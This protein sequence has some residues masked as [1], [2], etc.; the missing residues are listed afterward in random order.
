MRL[1]ETQFTQPTRSK[2]NEYIVQFSH[3]AVP[4]WDVM[5]ATLSDTYGY[6]PKEH[7]DKFELLFTVAMECQ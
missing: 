1:H 2:F 6:N 4:T 7:P 5:A 3:E